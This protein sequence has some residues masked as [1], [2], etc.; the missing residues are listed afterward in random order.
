MKSFYV[1]EILKLVFF[2]HW[3]RY[4]QSIS[5]ITATPLKRKWYQIPQCHIHEIHLRQC[6][7]PIPTA[8]RS[9]EWVRSRSLAGIA[10]SNPTGMYWCLSLVNVVFYQVDFS[11]TGWSLVQ[12]SPTER[13]CLRV[14]VCGGGG[15]AFSVIRRNSNHLRLEILARKSRE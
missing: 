2:L 4:R 9:K 14:C 6:A 10:G 5:S 11:A 1:T 12:R 15:G 7:M 8:A 13:A 3:R